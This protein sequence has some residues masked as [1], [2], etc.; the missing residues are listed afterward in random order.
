MSIKVIHIYKTF[1]PETQGGVE[2]YISNVCSSLK[3]YNIESRILCTS[4]TNRN[5]S[6]YFYK[7]VEVITYP[8]TFNVCS[9]PVSIKY[10]L[11]FYKEIKWADIIYYHY[12]WPFADILPLISSIK[13][14]Q[15][16][17]YHSDIVK[18]KLLKTI[19]KPIDN[20]FLS[21]MDKIISTSFQYASSSEN[22]KKFSKKVEVVPICLDENL[23]PKS[24]N[25]EC[26]K[27]KKEFGNDFFL[28]IGQLRY[29]K[30]LHL[31]LEAM[32]SLKT[33]LIIIGTGPLEKKIRTII[34]KKAIKNIHLIGSVD[35][36]T[37]VNYI[38]SCYSLVLPSH[39]RSEAFGISLLEGCM[40][41][42]PLISCKI[43]TGTEYINKDNYNG[44]VAL[45][46]AKSLSE[47][48]KKLHHDP[49][50]A[51]NMGE[52]SRKRFEKHFSIDILGTKLKTIIYSLVK[53]K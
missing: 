37:K 22:L 29:Y 33:N 31:L 40:M 46:N 34:R 48:M 52:N 13:I 45:P 44:F 50:L 19:L 18:Q 36:Q 47:C 12:P 21:K 49:K 4:K 17:T 41:G 43:G 28:F 51:L 15:I 11:N 16:S 27:I 9:C 8:E 24:E 2:Q 20:A 35:D 39:L 26:N 7:N 3:K 32:K 38:N 30:G 23:Y 1:L 53:K 42:K 5:R 10:L 25:S 14:P 6:S